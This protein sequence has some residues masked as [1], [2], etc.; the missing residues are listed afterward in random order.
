M[1]KRRRAQPPLLSCSDSESE[2]QIDSVRVGSGNAAA[3]STRTP[4][5]DSRGSSACCD[6]ID[7][8]S[9]SGEIRVL[10]RRSSHLAAEMLGIRAKHY[11]C[12]K[13]WCYPQIMFDILT[14]MILNFGPPVAT[15]QVIEWFS[16]IENIIKACQE[17]G[18]KSF[19]YDYA[20]D[21]THNMLSAEGFI[22]A[23]ELARSLQDGGLQHW[24][25]V[26]S[27]WV[28][29][30]WDKCGRSIARPMGRSVP[31]TI[32]GNTMV[33]RM[34]L[35]AMYGLCRRVAF[36]LEQPSS[37]LMFKHSRLRQRP[38]CD[39]FEYSTWMHSFGAP[40]PKRTILL[41][42]Q[43]LIGANLSRTI[44]RSSFIGSGTATT[45]TKHACATHQ[46]ARVYGA[47]SL[48]STQEYP[49]GYG[50]AVVRAFRKWQLLVVEDCSSSDSD[51]PDSVEDTWKDA[52]L[53]GVISALQT[54]MR[55]TP[56]GH[57]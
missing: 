26:C 11:R 17:V 25:T 23:M 33:S 41:A 4:G 55:S 39:F 50:R 24:A 6:I 28:W 36:V 3:S 9:D 38:F 30:A 48:K 56:S 47:R 44:R 31:S 12:L 7:S 46:K 5:A 10:K 21:E 1:T 42:D 53:S 37:S 20:K 22:V 51:Y 16:G 54:T 52:K 40:T 2:V 19:G 8:D 27:S 14:A 45:T 34:A 15:L 43:P 35:L 18:I 29:L 13:R 32:R 57:F 49:I